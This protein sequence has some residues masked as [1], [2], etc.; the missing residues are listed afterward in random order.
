MDHPTLSTKLKGL[1][2]VLLATVAMLFVAG[3]KGNSAPAEKTPE[4]IAEEFHKNLSTTDLNLLELR[5][6]VK[7]VVYPNGF[8]SQYIAT[9]EAKADTISF[10][11]AGFCDINLTIGRDSLRTVRNQEGRTML[12]Q[13]NTDNGLSIMFSYNDDGIV[14]SWQTQHTDSDATYALEYSDHQVSTVKSPQGTIRVKVLTSDNIGNW[15]KRQLQLANGTT[16]TQTR[17]IEYY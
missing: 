1:G 17:T 12:L 4:Q 9:P 14:T 8:I 11:P 2:A 16:L 13:G 15:T 3:C 6:N 10:S 7:Q 5:G